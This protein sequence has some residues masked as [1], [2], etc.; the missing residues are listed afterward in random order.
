MPRAIDELP[1]VA[2]A[3]ALADGE[4]VIRDAAE[5]RVKES[6]RVATTAT[7][8]G[9]LGVELEQRPDGM[10]VRGGAHLRAAHVD[11]SGRPPAGDAGGGG[12]PAGGR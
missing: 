12:G 3:G 11:S 7:V 9:A 1:L 4:T 6:D 2:L 5:L 10:A 8:L